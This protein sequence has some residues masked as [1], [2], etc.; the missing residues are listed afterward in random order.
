[1]AQT[2]ERKPSPIMA[3]HRRYEEAQAEFTLAELAES[4]A[5]RLEANDRDAENRAESYRRGQQAIIAES[6]ALRLAILHQ[7]PHDWRD[8]LTLQFH[9][10][11]AH[12]MHINSTNTPESEG[13]AVQTAIDTLFDFMCCEIDQDHAAVGAHFQTGAKRA[14][15]QRR[16][17]TGIVED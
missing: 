9:I 17:R 11:N 16:H 10:V 14:L 4:A 8:A 3:I 1:M 12:D 6:D 13:E 15:F 5:R 2:T 7:V